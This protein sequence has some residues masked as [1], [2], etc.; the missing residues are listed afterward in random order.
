MTRQPEANLTALLTQIASADL[1]PPEALTV[2]ITT[3]CN[4]R[5][6]HCW[7]DCRRTGDDPQR[8]GVPAFRKLLK[9]FIDLGG[10]TLCI[11]GGEPLTHPA[12]HQIVA[13]AC[14]E[15]RIAKVTLQTNGTLLDAQTITSLA[16]DIFRKLFFQVSLDGCSPATH[17]LFRGPGSLARAMTG[18]QGLAG[19]GC[20]SRTT[21][22][23]TEMRQNFEEIP[24]LLEIAEQLG[25]AA[26][27]GL[28]LIAEGSAR[29]SQT[30]QLPGCEQYLALVDRFE[31]DDEFRR[32]YH[33]LGRFSAIEWAKGSSAS[34]HA[35]CR[36]LEH[37]YVTADG[38]LFPCSL[39]QVDDFA[40]RGVY[41]RSLAD[42]IGDKLPVWAE[43]MRTSRARTTGLA[44]LESCAGGRHCGGGCL[45]RA[46]LPGRDLA[47]REDR[48][49]LRRAV[50]ARLAR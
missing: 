23:F 22:A 40:G 15:P 46:Y 6:A 26:V 49:G 32:R 43:L 9:E 45:A 1:R 8:V 24:R 12:W 28:T 5:C 7:V 35:G 13:D 21:I 37:P 19:A 14:A 2:A 48:C 27:V 38:M 10:K 39:L 44:C 3:G 4:L 18:L 29:N 31:S 34:V 33:K 25:V 16:G 50:Y 11:T 41:A 20:A 30:A 42:V 17:D 47:C 36:F